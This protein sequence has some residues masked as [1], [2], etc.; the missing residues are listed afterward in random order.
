M[1]RRLPLVFVPQPKGGFTVA[2]PVSPELVTEGNTLEEAF[3]NVPDAWAAV[4]E[5]YSEQ[6][7]S[8]TI[9]VG[10]GAP[11]QSFSD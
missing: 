7:R 8:P 3:A 10:Y 1:I 5:I 11:S 6:K 9:G 4:W 2:S